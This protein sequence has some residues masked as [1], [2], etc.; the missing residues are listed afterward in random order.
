MR[1]ERMSFGIFMAPFHRVGDNPNLAIRRDIE[2]IEWLDYLDYDEAW[3]GEHHSGGWE[4]I[5][6]P[7]LIIAV[8]AEK[9][10]HIRLGAGVASLPYHHPLMLA[11][12]YVQLD[13]M[14]RGRSMLGVGPGALTSDAHMLGIDPLTQ[15]PRM[16]EA[17]DVIV[18]LLHGERLT[19]KADWFEIND[20]RLQL[21]PYSR[22]C[23]PLAVA[24]QTSPVGMVTAGRY[25][26]GV[27]SLGAQM[28]G[29]KEA[30]KGH[31]QIAVDEAAKHG[32]EMR[33]EDW[34]IVIRV[35]VAETREQAI[36]DVEGGR[37][38][39]DIHYWHGTLN[40]PRERLVDEAI[41]RDLV[42]V[43]SPEDAIAAIERLLEASGGFGGL[44]FQVHEWAN[45]E[46]TWRSYELFA[47][48]VAPHF[49]HILEPVADSNRYVAGNKST[50]FAPSNAAIAKAFTDAGREMPEAV[51]RNAGLRVG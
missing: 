33:R 17:L 26:I 7:A 49:Q 50:I 28:L 13:H 48:W 36:R 31:W 8:A 37:I 16:E 40:R 42:I 35:H 20:A 3:I 12:R 34:K 5:A 44:L 6:D 9:T 15:R 14:T 23:F 27:L 25:G 39:E 45:R 29:G 1:P 43:G 46:A 10:R 18:R 32:R 21:L 47:R 4:T 22:P 30:L 51:A 24:S 11:D 2:L 19:Y 41:A 38:Y